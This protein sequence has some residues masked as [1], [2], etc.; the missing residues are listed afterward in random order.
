MLETQVLRLAKDILKIYII[1][2]KKCSYWFQESIRL[3]DKLVSFMHKVN[4]TVL[5]LND[6]MSVSC[7]HRTLNVKQIPILCVLQNTRS[8]CAMA[9]YKKG[10]K[11]TGKAYLMYFCLIL[12]IKPIISFLTGKQIQSYFLHLKTWTL[13]IEYSGRIQMSYLPKY[14]FPL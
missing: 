14:H 1:C 7:L 5:E 11:H 10:H 2:D 12:K 9:S 3:Q 13:M 6:Y 8:R 4:H